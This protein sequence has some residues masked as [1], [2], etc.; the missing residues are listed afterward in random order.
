MGCDERISGR[1]MMRL[2][3]VLG[4]GCPKCEKLAENAEEAA[5]LAGVEAQIVR[6]TD[7][8][9]ITEFEVMMTPALVVD[10]QVKMVGRVLSAEEIA[11]LLA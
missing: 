9:V 4:V 10:G 11:K 5:R 8:D 1:T 7:M 6:V 3:Q 2:I